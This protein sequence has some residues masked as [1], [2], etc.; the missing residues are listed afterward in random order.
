M[1]VDGGSRIERSGKRFT[2]L[3]E[4]ANESLANDFW[5]CQENKRRILFGQQQGEI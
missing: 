4:E 3:L 5:R 1:A 2:R